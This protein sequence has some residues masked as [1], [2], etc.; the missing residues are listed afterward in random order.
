MR[1]ELIFVET[2]DHVQIALWKHETEEYFSDILMIHGTFSD[3]KVFSLAT[4]FFTERGYNCW[5][6]EWRN[7]G[8]SQKSNNLFDFETIAHF[9]VKAIMNHLVFHERIEHFHCMTHSGGGIC[10]NMLL[11]VHPEYQSNILSTTMFACQ[12][13]SASLSFKHYMRLF[14][15]KG[16]TKTL[17]FIPGKKLKLGNHNESYYTM[18][19]WFNWNLSGRFRG[20]FADDYKI[21][22]ERIKTPTYAISSE[23]DT[24]IAPTASCVIF[25]GLLTNSENQFDNFALR[26][27]N[28]EDYGHSRVIYSRN[29]VTEIFPKLA[30]WLATYDIEEVVVPQWFEKLPIY[31]SIN[32]DEQLVF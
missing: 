16:L 12:A 31:E 18:K 6:M 29:A 8:A 17:G 5:V 4:K 9:D 22:M 13:F 30:D 11:G 10:L 15:A 32:N 25:F 3:K 19:Q 24:F 14:I 7:H 28:L 26:N 20:V 1:E 2:K 21:L 23:G 27:G